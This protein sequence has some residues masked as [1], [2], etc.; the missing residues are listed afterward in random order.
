MPS[1]AAGGVIGKGG[2][3]IGFIQKD[4]NVKMKMSKAND[5]YPNT[6]ERVCLITGSLS[7]LLKA[8]DFVMEKFKEKPDS[9]GMDDTRDVQV[10]LIT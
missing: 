8:H 6:Q 7:A 4:A 3:K 10:E 2:E 5:Y 1:Y 9:R